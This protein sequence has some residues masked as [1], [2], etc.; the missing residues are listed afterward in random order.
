MGPRLVLLLGASV[1]LVIGQA[2]GQDPVPIVKVG[3]KVTGNITQEDPEV[4]TK[5]LDG[6]YK[7]QLKDAPV[8][9]RRVDLKIAQDGV[10]T[11]DLRSYFFDAFRVGEQIPSAAE[12]DEAVRMQHH[13]DR[14]LLVIRIVPNV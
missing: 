3:K 5:V 8:R 11:I 9:G 13:V 2:S 4:H 14:A 1:V 10:Y 6:K 12:M 7:W